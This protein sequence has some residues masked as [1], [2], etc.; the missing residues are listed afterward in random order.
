MVVMSLNLETAQYLPI[1]DRHCTHPQQ[2]YD[3]E[4]HVLDIKDSNIL[5]MY[6]PTSNPPPLPFENYMYSLKCM[7]S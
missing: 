1:S 5:Y 4:K 2:V 3:I 7:H 6:L